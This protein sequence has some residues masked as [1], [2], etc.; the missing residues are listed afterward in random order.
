MTGII[1]QEKLWVENK[2]WM[3]TKNVNEV[4]S[5]LFVAQGLKNTFWEFLENNAEI[6][7]F[8]KFLK[9]KTG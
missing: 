2:L 9:K 4:P 6:E 3:R 8:K 7:I 1:Y 5:E